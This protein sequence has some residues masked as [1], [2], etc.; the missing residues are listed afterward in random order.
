[1]DCTFG[2]FAYLVPVDKAQAV[3]GGH[4]NSVEEILFGDL[5]HVLDLADDL[6]RGTLYSR[7]CLEC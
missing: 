7:A 3:V 4:D 2:Y 5:Q 6:S 1:M